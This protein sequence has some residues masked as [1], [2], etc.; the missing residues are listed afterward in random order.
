M[1][2]GLPRKPGTPRARRG[3]GRGEDPLKLVWFARGKMCWRCQE[4]PEKKPSMAAPPCTRPQVTSLSKHSGFCNTL[5]RW[6][7][8]VRLPEAA[9]LS[10]TGAEDNQ[11][12]RHIS[13]GCQYFPRV[14]LHHIRPWA[15]TLPGS[16]LGAVGI[17]RNPAEVPT[18]EEGGDGS[19]S[20]P[21]QSTT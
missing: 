4:V 11:Y 7:V 12:T 15:Q 8:C 13:S 10:V 18:G 9:C 17:Q 2:N 21:V 3:K 5:Y 19:F 1:G 6:G 20:C 16:T 14:R